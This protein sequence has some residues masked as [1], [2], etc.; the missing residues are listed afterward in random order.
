MEIKN[1]LK[2]CFIVIFSSGCASFQKT[3]I[4]N[5]AQLREMKQD[6]QK[7][8][9]SEIKTG[10]KTFP[11]KS[12]PESIAE[13]DSEKGV[14]QPVGQDEETR[15]QNTAKDVFQRAGLYDA[16]TGTGTLRLVLYSYG[17]WNYRKLMKG[18]FID[19]PFMMLLPTSIIVKHHLSAEGEISGKPFKL[20]KIG[21]VKTVFHA[22]LF[23]LYPFLSPAAQEKALIRNLL[24]HI[25]AEIYNS[26]KTPSEPIASQTH[27]SPETRFPSGP[28]Y[29]AAQLTR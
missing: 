18:F 22:L 23:P 13:P 5:R 4:L 29:P 26:G 17:R 8:R 6:S 7:H 9:F 21:D 25:S 24:W 10:W 1:L 14:F 12:I 19:T 2:L 16:Q 15:F 3:Q 27:S 11:F 20:K 28:A